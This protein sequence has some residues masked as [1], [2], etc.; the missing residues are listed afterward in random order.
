V[1]DVLSLGLKSMGMISSIS[2]L[3]SMFDR[4]SLIFFATKGRFPSSS[5]WEIF[6]LSFC[7]LA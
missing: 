5:K 1:G 4:I 6:V 3:D 2:T 7:Q